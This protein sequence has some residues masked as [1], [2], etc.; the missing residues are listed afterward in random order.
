M[1]MD[2]YIDIIKRDPNDKNNVLEREEL[3]Y[4][5]KF[6]AVNDLLQYDDSMYAKDLRLTKED[7]ERILQ[8]VTHERD[9]FGSFSTVSSVCEILDQYDKLTKDGWIIVYNADW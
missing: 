8:L 9:Y 3:C 1:G 6:Y 7:L 4:W 2:A 5:R